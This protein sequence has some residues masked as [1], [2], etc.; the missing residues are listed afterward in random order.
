VN[1]ASRDEDQIL[2]EVKAAIAIVTRHRPAA[3]IFRL[4][5]DRA[6]TVRLVLERVEG[7]PLAAL[8]ARHVD[9]GPAQHGG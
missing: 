1:E 7:V 2:A 8:G 4:T 6:G 5:C 9:S 3:A